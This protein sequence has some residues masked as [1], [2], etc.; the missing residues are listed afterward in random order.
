M[1]SL[2]A[3]QRARLLHKLS[4][5][6]QADLNFDWTFWAR[7]EQLPPPGKWLV[8]AMIAGRGWGKTRPGSEW[9]IEQARKDKTCRIALVGK[10][11]ADYNGTMITGES[12]IL[13]K[14]PPW[15]MPRH[16][17][18]QRKLVWPNGAIAECF[19]GETPDALRGPQFKKAW[20]DEL[21][22]FKYPKQ[23]WDNLMLGLRIGDDPRCVITTTPRPIKTLKDILKERSTVVT[24][25]S[26]YENLENLAPAFAKEVLRQYEGTRLGRQELHGELLSDVPGALFSLD[27]FD[28]NRVHVVPLLSRIVI[29][30]DPAGSSDE[31]ASETGIVPCGL[32]E[33]GHGYILA[34]VSGHY[35]PGEWSRKAIDHYL[36]LQA[37][38]IVG[39]RNHGGEMVGHTVRMT[40]KDMGIE[41][42]YYDV[43]ASR[44]KYTRAE[45]IGALDEQGRIH[46]VGCLPE[47]EDQMSSWV[48]GMDSPDRLDS[49]VWGLS[50]LMLRDV[51]PLALLG[52]AGDRDKTE[53]EEKAE[54]LR[55]LKESAQYVEDEIKRTG[56]YFPD[57]GMSRMR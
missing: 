35:T 49:A 2:P 39:E 43:T 17:P 54:E 26:T 52:T 32:G 16:I 41:V 8:W 55:K 13:T 14:S 33:D 29:P 10:T 48:P 36:S 44:G 12:G 57:G 1:A 11:P 22:K 28:R 5:R 56:S 45:P 20:V 9:V 51:I 15:F 34:D 19:S 6:Q 47:L 53:E 50:A 21:A 3:S 38:A 42:V 46:V 27:R 31:E 18:S 23:T 7:P 40:A 37:N 30:I 4:R 25:G 24:G